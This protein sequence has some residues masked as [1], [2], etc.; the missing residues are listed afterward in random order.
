M[1][2]LIQFALLFTFLVLPPAKALAASVSLA[3][4]PNPETD[5]A[6]YRVYVGN[7]PRAYVTNYT[8]GKVTTLMV[9]NL[10]YDIDYTFAVTAFNTAGLE[11]EFSNEVQT[12]LTAPVASAAPVG[13]VSI[14]RGRAAAGIRFSYAD[15]AASSFR[16]FTNGTFMRTA[17]KPGG[18]DVII[19]LPGLSS[20]IVYAVQVSSVSTNALESALSAPVAVNIPNPIMLRRN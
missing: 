7:A 4:D 2:Y 12:R 13:L 16:V 15:T 5:I 10:A 14:N 9:T 6:G 11:S 19:D 18:T 1:K 20:G 17:P 3:W 8:L